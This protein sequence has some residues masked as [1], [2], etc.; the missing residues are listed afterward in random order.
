MNKFYGQVRGPFTA[1][2]DVFAK[3][4]AEMGGTSNYLSTLG[5]QTFCGKLV[6]ING[7]QFE[8]GQAEM[9]DFEDINVTSLSFGSD[10]GEETIIDFTYI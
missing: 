10:V 5:I 2:E 1:G 6:N 3:I 9:L 7:N 4:K 8:I